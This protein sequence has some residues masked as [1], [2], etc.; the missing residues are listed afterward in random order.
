[1]YL[2]LTVDLSHSEHC[3]EWDKCDEC[4]DDIITSQVSQIEPV[5]A[6]SY[7]RPALFTGSGY[8]P[9]D[10][11][12]QMLDMTDNLSDVTDAWIIYR[13]EIQCSRCNLMYHSAIGECPNC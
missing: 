4:Y 6:E 10:R 9:I 13:R 8:N 3:F 12:H 11:K 2:D 5:I 7:G 1:M